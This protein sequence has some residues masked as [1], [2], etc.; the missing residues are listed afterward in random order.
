[1]LNRK[2]ARLTT[3]SLG[4]DQVLFCAIIADELNMTF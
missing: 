3:E 1:M 2:T 4:K